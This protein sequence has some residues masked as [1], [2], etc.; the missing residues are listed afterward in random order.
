MA[1]RI[2]AALD[3]SE[4]A[5]SLVPIIADTARGAEATLRFLYVSPEIGNRVDADGHVV[6]YADQEMARLQAE[7]LDYLRRIGR[8][9]DGIDVQYAVRFG[10]PVSEILNEADDFGA[11]LI[12][13]ATAGRSGIKR[14]LLGSVAEEVLRKAR[15]PVLL[16]RPIISHDA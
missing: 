1:K 6:A 8:L 4:V 13:V 15:A 10:D 11:D 12:A 16:V 14:Q 3:R 2:L 5:E 9:H 7:A